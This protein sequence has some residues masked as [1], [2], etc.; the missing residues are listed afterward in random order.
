MKI[1]RIKNRVVSLALLLLAQ[2]NLT[3]AQGKPQ[4]LNWNINNEVRAALVYIPTTAKTQ[5][6]PVIFAFHGH[7]GTMRNTFAARSFENLWPEA[8]FICAQG[9][10]TIG[11]L[12]DPEGKK[13]GWS[14]ATENNRDLAFFDAMLATLKKDYQIDD[15][16]IYATGHSNGGGFTYLLWA[17]RAQ[18]FAAFAP[19][20]TTAG[21]LTREL[22]TPKPALH[23]MGLNDPLVKPFLQKVTYNWVLKLNGCNVEGIKMDSN[24]TF[25]SGKNDNDVVS[26]IHNGG[27]EY[28]ISANQTIISFFKNHSNKTP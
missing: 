19:T 2:V 13:T 8:I 14:M 4:V 20:A 24:T 28:P 7:G 27:H 18:I 23:L 11:L 3:F 5:N 10:N 12:T 9:L 22:K 1:N 21:R 25:Y 15:S 26:Y 16:R 17:K 6:T